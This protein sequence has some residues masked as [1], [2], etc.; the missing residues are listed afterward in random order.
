M[1]EVLIP[2]LIAVL[3]GGLLYRRARGLFGRREISVPRFVLRMLLTGGL[4]VFFILFP[5]SGV[6]FKILGVAL[7]LV[8]AGIGIFTT[9]IEH[10]GGDWYYIPNRYLGIVLV[11]LIVGRIAY[12]LWQFRGFADLQAAN[13]EGM[14]NLALN[15]VGRMLLVA[16]LIYYAVYN[17]GILGRRHMEE[18]MRAEPSGN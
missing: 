6:G 4:A 14:G 11:S 7:G 8:L 5:G 12:R 18:T 16:L 10:E 13:S 9:K 3:V 15:P 17:A 2:L 1:V